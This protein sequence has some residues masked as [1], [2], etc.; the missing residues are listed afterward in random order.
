MFSD[1][2]KGPPKRAF[3]STE[4]LKVMPQPFLFIA[5][6]E[7]ACGEDRNGNEKHAGCYAIERFAADGVKQNAAEQVAENAGDLRHGNEQ[8]VRRGTQ[9]HGCKLIDIVR[10]RAEK[11]TVAKAVKR[12]KY[13]HSRQRIHKE[14]EAQTLRRHQNCR[15]HDEVFHLDMAAQ[16]ADEE[17]KRDFHH[18][19]HG[20]NEPKIDGIDL[21][22]RHVIRQEAPFKRHG[23]LEEECKK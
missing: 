9:L 22:I 4:Y 10:A 12:G 6:E 13:Q 23:H 17:Q 8:A 14:A 20:E 19:T 7:K 5:V 11:C 18:S 2:T 15:K 21:N 3:K 16:A 1:K